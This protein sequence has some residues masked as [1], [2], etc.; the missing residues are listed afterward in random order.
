MLEIETTG[1]G[2]V[3]LAV[4]GEL[5][6][7]HAPS[8]RA[9]VTGLLNRGDV[10]AI[11]LDIRGVTFIDSTGLGTVVVA[12]RIAAGVGVALRVTAASPAAAR[13]TQFLGADVLAATRPGDPDA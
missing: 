9:A 4:R 6:M 1:R 3:S 7:L 5:D 11:T 2:A 12:H 8:L 10:T 13:L